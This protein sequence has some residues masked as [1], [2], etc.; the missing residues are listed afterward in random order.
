MIAP[1][2]SLPLVFRLLVPCVA[3]AGCAGGQAPANA[4]SVARAFVPGGL[5]WVGR[6]DA[7]DPRA[8]RFA[9]SATGFVGVVRGTKLSVRLQTVDTP[10]VLFQPVVDGVSGA[11]FVVPEGPPRTVVLRDHLAPGDHVVELYRE[12]EG[13]FGVSV[14]LGMV[15]GTV[16]GAPPAPGRLIEFVGDSISAGYGNLGTEVHPPWDKTCGFSIAAES[17]TQAYDSMVGR[18]LGA[19]VSILARSGWGIYRDQ[20]GNTAN[21]L[22]ALYDDTVGAERSPAWSFER[23]PDAVVINLGTNDSAG[24]DPGVPYEKAYLA[25]LRTVR[26]HYPSARIFLTLGPMTTDPTLTA[27]RAHLANVIAAFGD[28]RTSKIDLE[29]QDTASTGCDYHPNVAEDRVV[30]TAITAALRATLEW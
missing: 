22:S 25:F 24:G 18:D 11:R 6:V 4:R 29:V 12:S 14:F 20:N 3:A 7:S 17:A 5:R 1:R 27:M 9:W 10:A 19:E 2:R 30:A 21:V 16:A 8:I 26:G 15:D 13:M 28:A 23:Q